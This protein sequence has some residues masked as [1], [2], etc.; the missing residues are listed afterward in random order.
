MCSCWTKL[1]A[2]LPFMKE[3]LLKNSYPEH[4]TKKCFKRLIDNIYVVKE[5]TLTEE[6][7][8]LAIVILYHGLIS[9]KTRTKLKKSLKIS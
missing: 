2:E 1:H 8:H 3:I 9:V 6:K 7:K 5:T 4:V